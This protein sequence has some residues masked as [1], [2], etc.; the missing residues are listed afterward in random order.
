[1]R[2]SADVL[3]EEVGEPVEGDQVDPVIEV[4]VPCT[5]NYDEFFRLGGTVVGVFAEVPRVGVFAGYERQR[6]R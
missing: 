4:D 6:A 1:V 2:G 5:G 3:R